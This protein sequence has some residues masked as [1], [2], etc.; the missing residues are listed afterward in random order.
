M[1]LKLKFGK[2]IYILFLIKLKGELHINTFK[3]CV[4]M[5]ARTLLLIN[6]IV[7]LVIIKVEGVAISYFQP[8]SRKL[9]MS[10]V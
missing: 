5:G 4:H 1:T 7:D 3:T 8:F 9:K 2:L 10:T 6:V